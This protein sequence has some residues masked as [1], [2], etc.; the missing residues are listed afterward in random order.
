LKR[1]ILN[2]RPDK[3]GFVRLSGGDYHYLVH[4]KRLGPGGRFPA[5][6]GGQNCEVEI[7]SEDKGVL[8][9]K[10]GSE[11]R[12]DPLPSG[13]RLPP[14]I[15]FQAMPKG[16]KTDHIIRQAAEGALSEVVVFFSERSVP[17]FPETEIAR[18]IERW[19]RIIREARQQSGSLVD[20][21]PRLCSSLGAAL[22]YWTGLARQMEQTAPKIKTAALLLHE[23]AGDPLER[24]AFHEY[25][26]TMPGLVALAAGP[27]GGFSPGECGKF[28]EAGFGTVHMGDSV[29]RT[30]TAALYAAAAARII[31]LERKTWTLNTAITAR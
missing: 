18:R 11:I 27:E 24:G 31:L 5:V 25:L 2:E 20:T 22:S 21:Q 17:R 3:A 23:T 6:F 26:Y 13:G 29:L 8:M 12:Q 15:L 9:G 28:R 4:V 10:T 30:E 14:I 7:V 19:R 1:F 16:S